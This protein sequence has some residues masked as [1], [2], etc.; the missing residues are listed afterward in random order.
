[1]GI[2]ELRQSQTATRDRR[3]IFLCKRR[4]VRGDGT[5][6][7]VRQCIGLLDLEELRGN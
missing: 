1:M 7:I 4:I 2:D 3:G 6:M 5:R